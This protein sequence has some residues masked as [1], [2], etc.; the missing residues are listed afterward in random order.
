MDGLSYNAANNIIIKEGR[1]MKPSHWN[2]GV[3][4]DPVPYEKQDAWAQYATRQKKAK[5]MLVFEEYLVDRKERK[6]IAI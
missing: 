3:S 1:P 2:S 6:K 5:Q 4:W